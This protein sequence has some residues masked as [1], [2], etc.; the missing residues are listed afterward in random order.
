[1]MTGVAII[2][3]GDM[4]VIVPCIYRCTTE[5]FIFFGEVIKPT[6]WAYLPLPQNL[7]KQNQ[8]LSDD[9]MNHFKKLISEKNTK[10]NH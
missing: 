1:M 3:E 8:K 5:E 2:K 4:N 9:R 6:Y 10:L 7:A